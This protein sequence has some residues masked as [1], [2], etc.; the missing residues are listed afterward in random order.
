[1]ARPDIK[2]VSEDR[3]YHLLNLL[4]RAIAGM[5]AAISPEHKGMA[6]FAR[7]EGA[8]QIF[9]NKTL[10]T[11]SMNWLRYQRA[12]QFDALYAVLRSNGTDLLANLGAGYNLYGL[13]W[14]NQKHQDVD[15]PHVCLDF[16]ICAATS[17]HKIHHPNSVYRIVQEQTKGR[18]ECIH[19][20]DL[21]SMGRVLEMKH[22]DIHRP[23]TFLHE[24]LL[25]HMNYEAFAL[26]ASLIQTFLT[27]VGGVWITTDIYCK[28]G[29]IIGQLSGFDCT[30]CIIELYRTFRRQMVFGDISGDPIG[31]YFETNAEMQKFFDAQGLIARQIPFSS[32]VSPILHKQYGIET[33]LAH[34]LIHHSNVTVIS[35]K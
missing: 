20:E 8:F 2:V 35:A 1:M 9:F 23:P 28:E 25:C 7:G 17:T 13:L 3:H 19:W 14:A 34:A 11:P 29:V 27:T 15:K 5:C 22:D 33:R 26:L 4:Q 32:I 12:A 24:G 18:F 16:D 31:P 10:Y 21:S 30:P 6:G